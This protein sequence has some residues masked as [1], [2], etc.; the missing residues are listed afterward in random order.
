MTH[1]T[2]PR[3][4]A[5]DLIDLTAVLRLLGGNR[6]ILAQLIELFGQDSPRLMGEVRSAIAR[7]DAKALRLAAHALR[8]SAGYFG[9]TAAC[10]SAARLEDRGRSSDLVGAWDDYTT[11]ADAVGR[12]QRALVALALS[13]GA[14]AT[15]AASASKGPP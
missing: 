9:A 5:E 11:L 10:E 13:N 3:E 15:V 6:D 7:G 8:G 4:R 12:L 1:S 2:L 14:P